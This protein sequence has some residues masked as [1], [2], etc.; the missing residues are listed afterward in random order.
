VIVMDLGAGWGPG[1]S[2]G[3]LTLLLP[4]VAGIGAGAINTLVGSGTLITFPALLAIGM[5]PVNANITNNIGLVVGSVTGTLG[6]RRELAGQGRRL[7][8]LAG[9][10]ALGGVLGALLLLRLPAA[11][12]PTL[13]ARAAA[14]AARRGGLPRR[15]PWWARALLGGGVF[16]TGVYGGYFGAAQGILLIAILDLGLDESL[17]RINALKNALASIVNLVATIVFLVVAPSR[18]SWP[19]AAAVAAGA[20]IG[21]LLAA[22]FG[23]RLPAALLRGLIV[24]VGVV[25]I[26]VLVI[27]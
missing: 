19:V 23:R 25:A 27:T 15:K 1:S 22:R 2:G 11:V 4:L 20:L 6:Y 16:G 18:V 3:T 5:P 14:H 12:G 9:F 17:Q 8:R 7:L 10:S 13:S 24:A 21:G 26:V